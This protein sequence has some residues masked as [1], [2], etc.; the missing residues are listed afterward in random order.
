M[1]DFDQPQSSGYARDWLCPQM[2][3]F[4]LI[5][6]DGSLDRRPCWAAAADRAKPTHAQPALMMVDRKAPWGNARNRKPAAWQQN[7][8]LIPDAAHVPEPHAARFAMLLANS[9]PLSSRRGE[10]GG[11]GGG[12]PPEAACTASFVRNA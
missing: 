10:A 7:M 6:L 9:M 8:P 3:M 5:P 11:L 2:P 12:R 4:R 1:P